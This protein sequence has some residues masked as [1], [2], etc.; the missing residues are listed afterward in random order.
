M[1][2]VALSSQ[3]A[4]G[5]GLDLL[6]LAGAAATAALHFLTVSD[7]VNPY[8]IVGACVFWASFVVVRVRQRREI[9]REW[10]FRLD[11]LRE[12]SVVPLL[13]FTGAASVLAV[14]ALVKGHFSFPLHGVL[15]LLLYPVWGT[16]Q[17]F[18]VLGV[19]VGN[20]EKVPFLGENRLLLVLLG[21][22][23]FGAVHLPNL[24]LTAG[25][26]VLALVYVP[27][28]LRHRNVWPL[29]LVHGWLGSLF[30][31][32]ALNQDPWLRTFG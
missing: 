10:G 17:Q 11:N 7:G 32:W 2:R 26:T 29:G 20:L 14:Y 25:T 24:L 6:A 13:F 23:L 3:A 4:L 18:L 1:T 27:V 31:L 30:Y 28:F 16:I 22:I 15:L 5:G 19:V 21:A 12:A 8:F 9:L